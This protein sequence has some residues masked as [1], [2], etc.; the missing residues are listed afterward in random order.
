MK[1]YLS[2]PNEHTPPCI[3]GKSEDGV[4]VFIPEDELNPN[5]LEYVAWLFDGNTSEQWQPT[6]PESEN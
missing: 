4:V 2:I 6:Q 3:I 5:Y 1:Y